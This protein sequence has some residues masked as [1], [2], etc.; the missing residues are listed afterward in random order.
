MPFDNGLVLLLKKTWAVRDM[1]IIQDLWH[2]ARQLHRLPG[3]FFPEL[4][5][6]V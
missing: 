4:L 6:A 5:K 1:S 3:T 2:N